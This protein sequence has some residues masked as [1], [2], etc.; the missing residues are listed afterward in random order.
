MKGKRINV[1]KLLVLEGFAENEEAARALIKDRRV[2]FD[3]HHFDGTY[4]IMEILSD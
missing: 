4:L 2:V 3:G 1:V